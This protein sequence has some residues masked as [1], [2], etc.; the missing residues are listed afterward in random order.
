MK[1]KKKDLKRGMLVKLDDRD[2]SDFVDTSNIGMVM[3]W[4]GK[5]VDVLFINGVREE[6]WIWSLR[7]VG[8]S[9]RSC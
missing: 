7:E 8:D 5:R 1:I 4:E 6:H 9:W 2:W 3:S